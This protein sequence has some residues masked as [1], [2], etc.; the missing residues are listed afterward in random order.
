M[1][2]IYNGEFVLHF[3]AQPFP[4]IDLFCNTSVRNFVPPSWNFGGCRGGRDAG[5][6]TPPGKLMPAAAGGEIL[7]S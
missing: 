4:V 7:Q 3:G 6:G 2:P 5:L 1:L